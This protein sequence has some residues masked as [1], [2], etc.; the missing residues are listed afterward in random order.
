[1]GVI[2]ITTARDWWSW[3]KQR[4]FRN[5]VFFTGAHRVTSSSTE[6]QCAKNHLVKQ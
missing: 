2:L 3:K 4:L 6:N 5:E 1:M